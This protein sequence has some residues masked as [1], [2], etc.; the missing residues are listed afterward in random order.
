MQTFTIRRRSN[1][2]DKL[3]LQEAA[4]RSTHVGN[5]EMSDQVKWIR[6]YIVE[7]DDGRLGSVCIYQAVNAAAIRE[8]AKRAGLK[9]DEVQAVVKTVIV[10]DDPKELEAAA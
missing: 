4:A 3:E 9:A 2:A 8:H 6:S 10:R 1:W 5:N 7:E